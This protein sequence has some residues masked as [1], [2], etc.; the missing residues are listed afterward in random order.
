VGDQQQERSLGRLFERFQYRIGGVL[1]ES[2]GA[3]D[4]VDATAPH[5][6]P[7]VCFPGHLAHLIDLYELA[8]TRNRLHVQMFTRGNR[9]ARQT[10][11]AG[12]T[13][14]RAVA[15][16]GLCEGQGELMLAD[17]PRPRQDQRLSDSSFSDRAFEQSLYSF[18]SDK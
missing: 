4:Y 17:S 5:I 1:V 2:F 9:P 16:D 15:V 14:D 3:V 18:I 13:L 12:V 6:W 7:K 8:V 11:T 10:A